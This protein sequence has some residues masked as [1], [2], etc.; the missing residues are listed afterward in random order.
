MPSKSITRQVDQSGVLDEEVTVVAGVD[1]IPAD[2]DTVAS[3]QMNI[4]FLTTN[5]VS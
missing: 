3:G 5:D 1:A 4:I 2:R